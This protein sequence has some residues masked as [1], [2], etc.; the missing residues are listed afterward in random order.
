MSQILDGKI[1]AQKIKDELRA[2]VESLKK[3]FGAGPRLVS[4]L[5]GEDPAAEAYAGSQRRAAE[6]LGIEYELMKLSSDISPR[7]Y[8]DAIR[9]LN[10]DDRVSG[11]M[12][13]KPL[14]AQLNYQD[15]ADA[16]AH[17]KDVEGVGAINMGKLLMGDFSVVP[18]TPA[19]AM[20]HLKSTGVSLSG[21][22]AVVVGRSEIVG[23]PVALLLL[24]ENATVT[25]CHSKTAGLEDHLRRADV[26]VAAVGRAGFVKGEWIRPGA[27]VVDV[28]INKVE[29]KIVGDVKFETASKRA[30]FITPVPGG[31]GPVTAVM[32]MK[33]AVEGFKLQKR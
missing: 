29:D 12:L 13:L 33:N 17:T 22:E 6:N 24:K 27:I 23:K 14:P 4:L 3:T 25:V 5:V 20:E 9:K 11:V 32:L 28:G 31:V 26:V 19:A 15:A 2:E 18:C 8:L 10:A 16:I 21:K 30:S 1:L 7:D